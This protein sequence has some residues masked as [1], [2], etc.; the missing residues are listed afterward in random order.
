MT[1]KQ[2]C[3]WNFVIGL[4]R[5]DYTQTIYSHQKFRHATLDQRRSFEAKSLGQDR[6]T[7][8]NLFC[9]HIRIMLQ[10]P[11]LRDEEKYC[12]GWWKSSN[13]TKILEKNKDEWIV[14]NVNS[15]QQLL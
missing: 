12:N 9:A 3:D 10:D 6:M 4:F 8:S 15:K 5:S 13:E 7:E 2:L 11:P 14:Q 1:S